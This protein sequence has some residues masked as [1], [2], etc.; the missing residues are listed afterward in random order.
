MLGFVASN[1]VTFLDSTD[2]L[3]TL[4]LY[5]I[6]VI[7]GELAPLLTNAPLQ[8]IPLASQSVLVHIHLQRVF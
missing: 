4:S 7:I 6:Q 3:L 5:A 2:K 1:P 8:L